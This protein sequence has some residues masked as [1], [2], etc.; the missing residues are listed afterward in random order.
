MKLDIYVSREGN[1][2]CIGED[3][4]YLLPS[5][6]SLKGFKLTLSIRGDNGA[7]NE[8]RTSRNTGPSFIVARAGLEPATFGL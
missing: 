5:G 1:I 7:L 4:N 6:T 3:Q 8:K 2:T